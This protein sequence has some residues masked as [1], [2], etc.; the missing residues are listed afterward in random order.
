MRCFVKRVCILL[1][2]M[3]K[4]RNRLSCH[5]TVTIGFNSTFEGAN[6]IYAHTFFSGSMGYGTYIGEH[7]RLSAHIGRFTSIAPDVQC[8]LGVHPISKPYATTCPMFF[9]LRKQNGYTFAKK[10]LFQEM[11]SFVEI[12]S[13]CWIG[14]RCFLV[15]G[16][17][18]GHGAVV[19]AG[20]V[21]TKDVPPYA[22]VGGVPA[23]IL[24]YRYD[25]DTINF[26]LDTCWWNKPIEWLQ[27]HW[28][29][30]NNIDILKQLLK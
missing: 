7:C 26:L 10:N 23:K 15:G 8:N 20:A 19:L 29:A 14:Q 3:L 27:F 22:I 2:M 6:K 24:R 25:E 17:K 5:Y 16:I 11:K 9:S 28:E 1:Y 4:Y 21:V 30:L 12:G 18:I 13:D